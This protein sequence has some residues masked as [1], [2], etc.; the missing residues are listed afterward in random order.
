M[1]VDKLNAEL[2]Q[3]RILGPYISPPCELVISPL[4]V[5]PKSRP[6]KFRLIHDLSRPKGLS[7]ND[8]IDS[9]CKNVSY[10]SVLD[11]A[12]HLLTSHKHFGNRSF[13]A[14]VDL[15]DAYRCVPIRKED[16]KYLG[17]SFEDKY[18]IDTC[19]P[20]GLASSCKIFQSISD[21]LAW[22]FKVENNSCDI[23]NYLDDFLIVAQNYHQC[24]EALAN[25]LTLLDYLGFP[26]AKDKTVPP[27]CY[28]EFLGM[29]ID[30]S[31][32]SFFVPKEKREKM[33]LEIQDFA[34][35]KHRKVIQFQQ[36]VSKLNFLC[37]AFIPGR[38]L[39]GGLCQQLRGILSSNGYLKR[40][41]SH[42]VKN[43]LATWK[44]FLEQSAGRPFRFI[45]PVAAPELTIVT[46]ASGSIGFG[47]VMENQWF[48]G[49]WLD[50]WWHS[51][52]IALLELYPIHAALKLWKN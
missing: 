40:R 11:V 33:L 4:Y 13:L 52:N 28:V 20:M 7:V 39:L 14:K 22:M 32:L 17:M 41:V 5:I 21:A 2:Q 9:S 37:I 48:Q 46:D 30:S 12:A 16:W 49:L 23:F 19:L 15:K 24:Q 34:N 27:M 42:D 51:Q 47:C 44:S 45:D 26:V 1:L 29:G 10:C 38:A 43:D 6:G 18:L 35:A 3:G 50:D 25:F 36:L 8:H 31:S